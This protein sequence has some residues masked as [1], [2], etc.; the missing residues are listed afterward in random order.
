MAAGKIVVLNS[1][2]PEDYADWAVEHAR[3]LP[4]VP[5]PKSPTRW[6]RDF[7]EAFIGG[8]AVCWLWLQIV[9]WLL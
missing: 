6:L 8:Y 7:L 3:S 9:G 1:K 2:N 5:G 4:D